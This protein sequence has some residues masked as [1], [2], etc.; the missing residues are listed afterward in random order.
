LAAGFCVA[1]KS[2]EA[3]NTGLFAW[4][5]SFRAIL[6]TMKAL[7]LDHELA[8]AVIAGHKRSTWRLFDD[9]DLSV[10]D[11]V[12]LID[13]VDPNRP[14]TWKVIGI[15]KINTVIQKR[16]G[17]IEP[18]DYEG[19]EAYESKE[20]MLK[21][22]Q[23]HYG[24]DVNFDNVVKIIRFDFYN[25]S[26]KR[27]APRIAVDNKTSVLTEVK[28]FADGG[29]RGNPGPSALGYAIL[30]MDDQIVVKKGQYLGITTNNQAEYQALK[31]GLEEAARMRVEIVHVYMDSLLVINQ[32]LGV[33]KLK[34]RDLWP[35]HAAVKDIAAG[36][37]R[38]TYTHVPR[39]M[40]KI[41]DAAVNEALD[42][43]EKR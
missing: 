6:L 11:E 24:N 40:N 14:E 5:C 3:I 42:H 7:K 8:R 22:F 16:L 15:A 21:A 10:G 37:K 4:F 39:N 43:A 36:F 9:K 13:K 17:D 20:H 35:I 18:A 2:T 25:N 34:I 38:V 26:D 28:L 23:K 30:S 31:S 33:F 1:E 41:A 29:S 32:M 19:H 12:K 27:E